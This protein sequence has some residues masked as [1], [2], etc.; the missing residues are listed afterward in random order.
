[1][2][3]H[4]NIMNHS[5]SI[6]PCVAGDEQALSLVGQATF[7]ESLAGFVDGPDILE[8]CRH[9]HS[10]E[11]YADWLRRPGTQLW[12]AEARPGGAPVGYLALSPSD[13]DDDQHAVRIQRLYLLHRFHG[14]QLGRRLMDA[15]L[16][17]ARRQRK[18]RAV[19]CVYVKNLDGL[20]FYHRYGFLI[21]GARSYNVNGTDYD[22]HVMAIQL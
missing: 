12:L 19:L 6:R 20:A 5:Y 7:L 21:A 2:T 10:P 9:Q 8:H 13:I 3:K 17:H 14:Q 18:Q 22:N 15:A 4:A 16:S 1:M 11:L